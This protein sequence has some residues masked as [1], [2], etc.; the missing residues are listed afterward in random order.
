MLGTIN[1]RFR[2]FEIAPMRP[3]PALSGSVPYC[4]CAGST[5]VERRTVGERLHRLLARGSNGYARKEGSAASSPA[6]T[7]LHGPALRTIGSV[8]LI[9]EVN[10]DLPS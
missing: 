4:C 10:F 1:V 2:H 9:T 6:T 3:L 8:R 5:T 7:Q